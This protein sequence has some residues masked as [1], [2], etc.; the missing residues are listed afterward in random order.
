MY[1]LLLRAKLRKT[2]PNSSKKLLKLLHLFAISARIWSALFGIQSCG[3]LVRA[4][5]QAS[6]PKLWFRVQ[7]DPFLN[8]GKRRRKRRDISLGT[9]TSGTSPSINIGYSTDAQLLPSPRLGEVT[10]FAPEHA[11]I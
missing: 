4:E 5:Y 3:S 9:M 1:M 10:S 6:D 7:D 2:D 8:G 11:A